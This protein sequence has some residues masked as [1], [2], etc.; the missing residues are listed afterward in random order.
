FGAA[1]FWGT[2]E[3]SFSSEAAFI[4]ATAGSS[5]LEQDFST[6]SLAA[7]AS[8]I[9]APGMRIVTAESATSA[10]HFPAQEEVRIFPGSSVTVTATTPTPILTL[11]TGEIWIHAQSGIQVHYKNYTF[12]PQY[13]A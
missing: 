3:S 1:F 11:D 13:G 4:E 7:G 10:I 9:A 8:V 2:P 12:A 6:Q 5:T